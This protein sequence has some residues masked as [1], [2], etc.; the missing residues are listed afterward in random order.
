MNSKPVTFYE[1]NYCYSTY[2]TEQQANECCKCKVCGKEKSKWIITGQLGH[3][4]E[5]CARKEERERINRYYDTAQRITL[6]EY[7]ELHKNDDETGCLFNGDVYLFYQEDGGNGLI[8]EDLVFGT[9]IVRFREQFKDV[10]SI[11]E[12]WFEPYTN[13]EENECSARDMAVGYDE[14][15]TFL[16]GW[17]AKQD[18]HYYQPDFKTAVIIPPMDNGEEEEEEN[19][20]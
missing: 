19:K 3:F 4:C 11:V 7:N 13:I 17:I 18:A 8:D 12:D 2:R 14:L 9:R 1:C 10:E 5:K 20:L 16:R 15:I 6:A